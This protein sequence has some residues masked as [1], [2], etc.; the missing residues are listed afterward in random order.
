MTADVDILTAK[1]EGV[2]LIPQRAVISTNGDKLVRVLGKGNEVKQVQ[3][4]TG[5]R[6]SNGEIEIVEGLTGGEKVIISIKEK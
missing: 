2:I 3:V 5:L 4:K 1:K 6:G